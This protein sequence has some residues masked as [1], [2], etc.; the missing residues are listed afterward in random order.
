MIFCRHYL[1]L[2]LVAL[3]AQSRSAQEVDKLTSLR[4]EK[5]STS[6]EE[7]D[8]MPLGSPSVLRENDK[9]ERFVVKCK[10]GLDQ[11]ECLNQIL[12]AFPDENAKVLHR[13]KK[14][15]T[16]AIS[17]KDLEPGAM[18]KHDLDSKEDPI[19]QPL[20]IEESLEIHRELQ[21]GAQQVPYGIDMVKAR[22]VWDQFGV[23][24]ENVK[25]CVFDTG[26]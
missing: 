13:L 17:V 5:K 15:N 14:A 19:R 25:V 24:G 11:E 6:S 1:P 20:H 8:L 16:Y 23:R 10:E 2:V 21:V 9:P 26:L 3:L 7:T 18:D 4:K 22:D 12:A